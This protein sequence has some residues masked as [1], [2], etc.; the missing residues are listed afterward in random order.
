MYGTVL[1]ENQVLS[2]KFPNFLSTVIKYIDAGLNEQLELF[3]SVEMKVEGN[4]PFDFKQIYDVYFNKVKEFKFGEIQF[5]NLIP[6]TEKRKRIQLNKNT[7]ESDENKEDEAKTPKLIKKK[8]IA[9]SKEE[10]K[11]YINSIEKQIKKEA[12]PD[13][14]LDLQEKPICKENESMDTGRHKIKYYFLIKY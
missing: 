9:K 7:L 2:E 12:L 11:A 5:N 14:K 13:N 4:I 10:K 1:F 8:K 6:H 3:E